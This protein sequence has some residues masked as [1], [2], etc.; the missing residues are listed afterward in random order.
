VVTV[1]PEYPK[2]VSIVDL[3][4]LAGMAGS[5]SQ[6]RRLIDQG[7]VELDG[8]RVTDR[9]A[10]TCVREGTLLKVGKRK[11]ARFRLDDS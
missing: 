2:E 7:G 11:F 6:V 5:K 10:T 4:M 3:A 9:E 8:V 1:P